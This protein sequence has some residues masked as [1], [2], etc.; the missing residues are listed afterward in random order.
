MRE[1]QKECLG[2]CNLNISNPNVFWLEFLSGMKPPC[3]NITTNHRAGKLF[4]EVL[5]VSSASTNYSAMNNMEKTSS[6]LLGEKDC[7]M[8]NTCG[9]HK[10][11]FQ[12]VIPT[13]H[14]SVSIIFAIKLSKGE[15][16]ENWGMGLKYVSGQTH[17]GMNAA[18]QLND[19]HQLVD[20][21]LM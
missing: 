1:E 10:N 6:W 17:S 2:S 11:I 21:P 13:L 3:V 7:N 12:I 19:S 9:K 16:Q 8:S 5:K 4:P 14:E 15:F 20:T 18:I